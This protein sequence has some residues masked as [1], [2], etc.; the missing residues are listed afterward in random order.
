MKYNF[1]I[2]QTL[3]EWEFVDREKPPIDERI[4]RGMSPFPPSQG[5]SEERLAI[6]DQCLKKLSDR[7][8]LVVG[9][10]PPFSSESLKLLKQKP[11]HAELW[12]QFDRQVPEI[13]KKYKQ[14]LVDGSN[15]ANLGLN[16]SY[17][18]DGIHGAETYQL[19][20]LLKML[21]DSRVKKE[22]DGLSSSVEAAL[23]SEASNPWQPDYTAMT[24]RLDNKN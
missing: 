1:P 19:H 17:L 22:L 23:H 9:I 6:L 14:P 11:E 3:R 20:L 12:N 16:D 24:R 18:L 5:I 10:L 13:F 7:G 15:P 4:R 8:I 2:P 21:E